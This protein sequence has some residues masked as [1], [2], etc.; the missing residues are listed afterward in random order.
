MLISVYFSMK[1][2]SQKFMHVRKVWKQTYQTET[3]DHQTKMVTRH[4]RHK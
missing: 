4:A 1:K 3:A 2:K